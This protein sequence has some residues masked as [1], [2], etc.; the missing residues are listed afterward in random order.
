M[1]AEKKRLAEIRSKLKTAVWH[2][3]VIAT[4]EDDLQFLLDHIDQLERLVPEA[5]VLERVLRTTD[6]LDDMKQTL[7]L[8]DAIRK[9][10]EAK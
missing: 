4:I 2:G 6:T 7:M 5:D 3:Y 1:R 8:I 10:R 9:Y